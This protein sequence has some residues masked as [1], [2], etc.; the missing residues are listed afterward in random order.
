MCKNRMKYKTDV[1]IGAE[2][3]TDMGCLARKISGF[4][5]DAIFYSTLIGKKAQAWLCDSHKTSHIHMYGTVS[6]KITLA[7]G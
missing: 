6:S 3:M 1:A 2:N 7:S 4:E 5:I